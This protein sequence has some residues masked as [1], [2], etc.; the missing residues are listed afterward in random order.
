MEERFLFLE[1]TK[2]TRRGMVR[3]N[4]QRKETD[5]R[6]TPLV[7]IVLNRPEEGLAGLERGLNRS[8]V[9]KSKGIVPS[10]FNSF[11]R[12]SIDASLVQDV[13]ACGGRARKSG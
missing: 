2:P 11:E 5:L 4:L 7:M 6:P 9:E 10:R 12:G 13:W 8:G 1:K 3:H